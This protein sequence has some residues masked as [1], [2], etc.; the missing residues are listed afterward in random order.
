MSAPGLLRGL[1]WS[2]LVPALLLAGT[3]VVFV[4]STTHAASQPLWGR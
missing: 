3:G 2:V 4:W 1:A